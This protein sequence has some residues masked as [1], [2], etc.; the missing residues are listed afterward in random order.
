MRERCSRSGANSSPILLPKAH[1]GA[2]PAWSREWG[3]RIENGIWRGLQA[4]EMAVP[5]GPCVP[6]WLAG[7]GRAAE[8]G[9]VLRGGRMEW[10]PGT[11]ALPGLSPRDDF[12]VYRHQGKGAGC[13]RPVETW[14]SRLGSGWDTARGRMPLPLFMEAWN[15]PFCNG[16]REVRHG[17]RRVRSPRE[18]TRRTAWAR[19]RASRLG[20]GDDAPRMRRGF[21]VRPSEIAAGMLRPHASPRGILGATQHQRAMRHDT[22]PRRRP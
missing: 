3:E 20:F 8:I 19:R 4:K 2:V 11:T 7:S 21:V 15:L 18:V 12:G 13:L 14:R 16:C 17:C 22:R 10:R 9:A 1:F 5:W 6:G